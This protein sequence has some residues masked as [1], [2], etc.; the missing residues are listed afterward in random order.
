MMKIFV[1][2][3]GLLRKWCTVAY[4]QCDYCCGFLVP[5][6]DSISDDYGVRTTSG[7]STFQ[8]AFQ[9]FGQLKGPSLRYVVVIGTDITQCNN[10]ES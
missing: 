6:V 3:S 2:Y 4:L 5:A 10:P 8:M 1:K 7:V 9:T